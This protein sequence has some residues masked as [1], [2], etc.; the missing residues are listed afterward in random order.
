MDK[1]SSPRIVA[2][3][4]WLYSCLL[5]LGPGAFRRDYAAPALQDFRRYCLDTHS[6]RG[7]FGVL[8]L[9]PLLFGEGITGMF[10]EYI[11]ELFGRKQPMLPTVCRSMVAAFWAF[12]LFTICCIAL[13][14]TAD[15]GAPFDA[16]GRAHP[17]ISFAHSIV[18]YGFDIALLAVALG[19]LPLLFIALKRASG[20]GVR[21]ILRLFA[22]GPK[23]LLRLLGVALLITICFLGYILATEYIFGSPSSSP[24]ATNG[25]PPLLLALAFVA[26]LLVVALFVFVLMAIASLFSVAV[27]RTDFGTAMLRFALAPIA[28]LTLV[29]AAST[30]A[31]AFWTL[32]LWTDAP[33]FAASGAG[34]GNGQTAWVI[35]IIAAM[36]FS[37]VVTASAFWRGLQAS[38]LHTV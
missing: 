28:L 12:V 4:T 33:Q 24:M 13:G 20:G 34:L 31:A 27:L 35:A 32:R 2:L 5:R 14:R 6:A 30:L 15:P 3:S 22:I 11:T 8:L 21:G 25:Q 7:A 18:N 17:E 19:G 38:R 9:W 16:V 29:M 23:Q 10:A 1:T 36:A 26:L 37:T